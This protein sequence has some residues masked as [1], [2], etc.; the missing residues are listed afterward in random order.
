MNR[1]YQNATDRKTILTFDENSSH[2]EIYQAIF[3]EQ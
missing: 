2:Q 1:L 3:G